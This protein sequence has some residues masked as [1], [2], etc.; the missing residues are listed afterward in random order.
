[1][2]CQW[3]ERKSC[4]ALALQTDGSY[5]PPLLCGREYIILTLDATRWPKRSRGK[6]GVPLAKR[7]RV[8]H[9]VLQ[10]LTVYSWPNAY[11]WFE[12]LNARVNRTELDSFSFLECDLSRADEFFLLNHFTGSS[13][14]LQTLELQA[15]TVSPEQWT[16]L[17]S[18]FETRHCNVK[19]LKLLDMPLDN[20][21]A[22][23]V[24]RS[25]AFTRTLRNVELS[26]P[27]LFNH[28]RLLESAR[29]HMNW[30]RDCETVRGSWDSDDSDGDPVDVVFKHEDGKHFHL[31]NLA[32]DESSHD[33]KCFLACKL[34]AEAGRFPC[35]FQKLVHRSG[36]SH[37]LQR[38][39]DWL[40]GGGVRL[41]RHTF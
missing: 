38:V 30:V 22:E 4:S 25:L 15:C 24:C 8:F 39:L 18:W 13:D 16:S 14:S 35:L 7:V 19:Q 3:V 31:M 36:D 41:P 37:L 26:G 2:A 23:F 10:G 11:N 1:M 17:A 21:G 32:D 40:S 33:W 34:W 28:V 20:A 29:A 27:P 9:L 5:D 6:K 12:H